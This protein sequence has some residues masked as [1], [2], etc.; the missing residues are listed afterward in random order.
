MLMSAKFI[1]WDLGHSST[2]CDTQAGDFHIRRSVGLAPK[3]A[4]EISAKAP[5]FASKTTGDKYPKCC[6]LNFRYEP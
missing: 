5:N 1:W 4:S 3:F 6:P 2:H